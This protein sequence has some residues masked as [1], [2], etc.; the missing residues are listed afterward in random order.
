MWD[1]ASNSRVGHLGD[2]ESECSVR[3]SAPRTQGA[4]D[5]VD[6]LRCALEIASIKTIDPGNR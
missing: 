1:K 6:A 3:E 5:L 2:R 4:V